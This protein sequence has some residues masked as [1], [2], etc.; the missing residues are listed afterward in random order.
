MYS[1]DTLPL[2]VREDM[3]MRLRISNN[4]G[5]IYN[6]DL[7][8]NLQLAVSTAIKLEEEGIKTSIKSKRLKK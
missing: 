5:R 3:E 4:S 6:K 8:R 7:R 2:S 1:K